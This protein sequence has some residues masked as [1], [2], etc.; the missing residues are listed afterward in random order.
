M[1]MFLN[2]KYFTD[3]FFLWKQEGS[4][5][6]E[7]PLSIQRKVAR[8]E[9]RKKIRREFA[10]ARYSFNAEL[11]DNPSDKLFYKPIRRNQSGSSKLPLSQLLNRTGLA[12][13]QSLCGA[14]A[15]YFEKQ[16]YGRF[17][18]CHKKITQPIL[19][20]QRKRKPLRTETT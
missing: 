1:L 2:V 7:H 18:E 17:R 6:P 3:T 4:P 15:S 16:S 8:Y 20:T 14:F 12:D 10:C 5:S 13:T 19:S 9:T 11:I